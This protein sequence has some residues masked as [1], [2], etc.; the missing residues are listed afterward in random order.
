MRSGSTSAGTAWTSAR[1]PEP[2]RPPR[3]RPTLWSDSQSGAACSSHHG[4]V[5]DTYSDVDAS[6]DPTGAAEWQDRVNSWPQV[7][8]Y[9]ARTHALLAGARSVLDIGCGTGGD[10]VELGDERAVGLDPSQMM[11]TTAASRGVIVCR[12]EATTLPFRDG[13]FDGVRADRVLQHLE[14]PQRA[15]AEMVRV[16]KGGG[17]VVVADPE[18]ES[19]VVRVPGVRVEVLD[20]IKAVRRD[21]GVRNGR[22]ISSLPA[23]FSSMGL[24]EITIDLF[25]LLLTDPDDAFGLPTW[26]RRVRPNGTGFSDE[27]LAAWEQGIAQAEAEGCVYALMYFVVSG[28]KQ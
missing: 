4:E 21:L 8:A 20:R 2:T 3:P 22:L 25:P 6:R 16:L 10:I 17:R 19:L 11:C 14:D 1:S 7:R 5:S 13:M 9:K 24:T 28:R 27:D 23:V 18:Q 15:I 12:G 26:A